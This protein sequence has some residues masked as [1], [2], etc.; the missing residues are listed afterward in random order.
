MDNGDA[1]FVR[2]VREGIYESGSSA[3]AS[4]SIS[5]SVGFTDIVHLNV[6]DSLEL[7]VNQISVGSKN[8]LG[9]TASTYTY[10]TIAW[11]GA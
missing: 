1:I 7:Q 5:L 3:H 4:Q 8:L 11:V 9:S 2:L 6:G 10:L